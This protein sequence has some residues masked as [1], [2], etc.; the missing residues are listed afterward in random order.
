MMNIQYRES[1]II[2]D[3]D[4]GKGKGLFLT[5]LSD[6]KI[7]LELYIVKKSIKII[8][9]YHPG[10]F[11]KILFQ[12]KLKVKNIDLTEIE[13]PQQSDRGVLCF[14]ELMVR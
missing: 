11:V 9:I 8:I 14:E 5:S 12:S 4:G 13:L 10:E 1:I 3:R 2:T 7:K 6:G